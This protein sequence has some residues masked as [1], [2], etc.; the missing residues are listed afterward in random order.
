MSGS[1]SQA[2]EPWS[3]LREQRDG[4]KGQRGRC[5]T[6]AWSSKPGGSL[7]G[8]GTRG[9]RRALEGHATGKYLEAALDAALTPRFEKLSP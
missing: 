8:K 9:V 3:H 7:K 2:R 4:E 1:P 6:S 5:V